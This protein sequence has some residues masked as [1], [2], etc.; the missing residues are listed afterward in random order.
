VEDIMQWR[1]FLINDNK[2]KIFITIIIIL[3]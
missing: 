3:I 1:N 2:Y